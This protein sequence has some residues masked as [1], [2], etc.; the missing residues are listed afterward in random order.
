MRII[1]D[2]DD[3]VLT[4]AKSLAANRNATVGLVISELARNELARMHL[5]FC[6]GI[7]VLPKGGAVLTPEFVENLLEHIDLCDA[8]PPEAIP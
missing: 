7:P 8:I 1:L 6:N 4:A 3:D 2:I 5:I